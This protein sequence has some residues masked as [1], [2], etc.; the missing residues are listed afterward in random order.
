METIP[1]ILTVWRGNTDAQII[2]SLQHLMDYILKYIMKP[3]TG[4]AAF[5][6]TV[7]SLTKDYSEES[8]VCKLFGRILLKTLNDHDISRTEAFKIFSPNDYV[9]TSRPLQSVNVLSTRQVVANSDEDNSAA[10]KENLADKYW[11]RESDDNYQLAI[12]T[13]QQLVPICDY[14]V[15]FYFEK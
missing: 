13:W 11:N 3:E 7:R 15:N 4:S 12:N 1:E 9:L 14:S 10:V 5:T 8:P 2:Q 6:D